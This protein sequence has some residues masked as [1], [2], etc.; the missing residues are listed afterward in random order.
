M[1]AGFS[2]KFEAF[3]IE[4]ETHGAGDDEGGEDFQ[5][6]ILR[7][8]LAPFKNEFVKALGK[9]RQDGDD[10]AALDDNVEEVALV[11]FQEVFRQQQMAG[12]RNGNELGD[13][14]DHSQND[15]DNPVRHESFGR[16]TGP[17]GKQEV[18]RGAIFFAPR[19][20]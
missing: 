19:R 4:H 17:A 9:Q 20:F 1:G 13:S 6:V 14:F 12:G 3:F 18:T 8:L 11:D 15:N 2:G 7:F 10:R 5:Q 16:E